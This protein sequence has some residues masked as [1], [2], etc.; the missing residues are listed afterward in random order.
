MRVSINRVTSLIRPLIVGPE[1]SPININEASQGWTQ[2]FWKGGLTQGNNLWG[3][4][5]NPSMQS[6]LE[7]GGLGGCPS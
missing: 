7:L 6:M 4:K 3:R 5:S 2:D 1:G